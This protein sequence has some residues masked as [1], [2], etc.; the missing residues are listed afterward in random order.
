MRLKVISA[1]ASVAGAPA[2]VCVARAQVLFFAGARDAGV[3]SQNRTALSAH[4]LHAHSHA[5]A[6]ALWLCRSQR[7][8]G[9]A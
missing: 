6:R 1:A 7:E 2:E 9:G 3:L 8:R 5:A 4:A